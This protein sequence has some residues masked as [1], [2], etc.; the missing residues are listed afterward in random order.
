MSAIQNDNLPRFP[1]LG[2]L[3][4]GESFEYLLCCLDSDFAEIALFQWFL[5][6]GQ[7]QIGDKIEL[8]LPQEL[9]TKYTLKDNLE[10]TIIAFKPSDDDQGIIYQVSLSKKETNL[11]LDS[12]N[13]Y[14]KQLPVKASLT[15]LLIYLIK[16]CMLIKSGVRIYFKH[17]VPYFSRISRYSDREYANLKTYFLRDIEMRMRDNEEKLEKLY[18][19]TLKTITQSEEIPIYIDLEALREILESEISLS[20]FNIIFSEQKKI[21][22]NE[23]FPTQPE[24]GIFMYL[25]AIKTLEKRLYYNFNNVVMLYLKSLL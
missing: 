2:S 25:H 6:R 12:F 16:D 1:F 23:S 17:F 19:I 3:E 4:G 9:S 24:Y 5:S 14:A 15:E 13:Q 22:I 10:G 8:Y 7:L 20:V 21:N 18:Q 11:K